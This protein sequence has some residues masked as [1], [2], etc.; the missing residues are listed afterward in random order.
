MI[1]FSI[2]AKKPSKDLFN[3]PLLLLLWDVLFFAFKVIPLM[4]SS[5]ESIF[6][7]KDFIS[8]LGVLSMVMVFPPPAGAVFILD[9]ICCVSPSDQP[10]ARNASNTRSSIKESAL[11][12]A[13]PPVV[14]VFD[15]SFRMF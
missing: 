4:A 14:S 11:L 2:L 1:S 7:R 5:S 10:L 9:K 3:L 12:P 13:A 6:D 8:D 15:V